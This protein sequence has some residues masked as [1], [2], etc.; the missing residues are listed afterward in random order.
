MMPVEQSVTH[1]MT[2]GRRPD[3]L[4]QTL[5]S[6]RDLPPLPTLAINDFGDAETN[7][8]FRKF[9]P[10]GRL[11]GPGQRLGHHRAID[12]LYRHVETALIFHDEDDWQFSRTDF[13]AD[14]MRLLAADPLIT[15]VCVRDTRDMPL[16]PAARARIV[17]EERAGIGFQRL[18][19]LHPQWHGFTMNPHLSRKA[20]WQEL[21][22]F[23]RFEK[24]RHISRHLRARGG[25]V[26]FLLPA[27]CTHIGEGRSAFHKPP[28][29]LKRLSRWLRGR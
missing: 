26:A 18:D 20:L 21:G 17:T 8:V 15:C 19:A 9:C 14:A 11:V 22:G 1:C 4:A 16:D 13:L 25:Y 28:G 2:I 5:A 7:A 24:E 6:L 3:L 12:E 23:A 29:R 10:S 27:A